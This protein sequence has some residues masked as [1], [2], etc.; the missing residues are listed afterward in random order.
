MIAQS[1]EPGNTSHGLARPGLDMIDIVVVKNAKVWWR[2][3]VVV[4]VC[5]EAATGVG[6][7]FWCGGQ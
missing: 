5:A 6:D 1:L 2:D 3:F 7:A 4:R